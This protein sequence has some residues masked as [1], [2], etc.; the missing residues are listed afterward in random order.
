MIVLWCI[1]LRI[2]DAGIERGSAFQRF[3]LARANDNEIEETVRELKSENGNV[4][5]IYFH[6]RIFI[7]NFFNLKFLF[8]FQHLLSPL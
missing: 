1:K 7:R 6:L 8:S 5:R 4:R 2:D 3:I